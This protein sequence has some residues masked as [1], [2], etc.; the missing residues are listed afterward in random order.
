MDAEATSRKPFRL[1]MTGSLAVVMA[2]LCTGR[3]VLDDERLNTSMRVLR[4]SPFGVT[5]TVERIEAAARLRGQAVIARVDGAGSV[6]VLASSVG[7]TPVLMSR[8][9]ALPDIPLSVQVRRTVGGGAD[10]LVAVSGDAP[11][12][13]WADL[14]ATVAEDLAALPSLLESALA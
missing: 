2:S 3:G 13:A 10:V 14:P 6:I 12:L 11:A 7:G 1:W 9:D 4:H 8:A 5:E